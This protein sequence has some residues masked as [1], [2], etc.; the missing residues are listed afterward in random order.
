MW[1]ARA[2]GAENLAAGAGQIERKIA[3][4]ERAD[5]PREPWRLSIGL[6]AGQRAGD[7]VARLEGAV[8]ERGGFTLGPLDLDIGWRDRI[9][10]VGRNGSGKSTLIGAL[11]GTV[12]LVA[13]RRVIGP[14]V[15]PGSMDQARTALPPQAPLIEGFLAGASSTAQDARSLLAKFGLEADDVERPVAELSPGERSRAELALLTARGTNFLI[16]DEPT[17]HLDLAAIEP[18]EQALSEFDG[19]L[20]V[21][22]HD[23]RFIDRVGLTRTVELRRGRLR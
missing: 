12:P 11:L 19:T 16:L 18:L 20:L 4:L 8:A 21:V 3:R 1:D 15:V 22:S 5:K 17:N 9:A 6:S 13:G 2:E 23:R 14:S 10:L 7:V